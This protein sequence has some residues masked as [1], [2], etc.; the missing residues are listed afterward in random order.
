MKHSVPFLNHYLTVTGDEY[1][2]TALDITESDESEGTPS[3][4]LLKAVTQL[5]TYAS[6]E[7]IRFDLKLDP[8]GTPFQK[9][10][11]AAM[12]EIPYGETRSYGDLARAI[13]SPKAFRAVGGACNRNPIAIVVSCHRVI[14]ADGT[15]TGYAGGLARKQALLALEQR[16]AFALV[17]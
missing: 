9:K 13:G 17:A 6:G 14:G 15:L 4:E 1:V 3:G 12:R 10:V 5:K 2:I 11:W 7:K 16:S 8:K